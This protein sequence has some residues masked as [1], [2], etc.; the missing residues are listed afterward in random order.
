M[1]FQ[2]IRELL[3]R[4]KNHIYSSAIGRMLNPIG[5]HRD[6]CHKFETS[7]ASFI[8]LAVVPQDPRGGGWNRRILQHET[9]WIERLNTTCWPGINEV[10][11]YVISRTRHS[12]G[13][14]LTSYHTNLLRYVLIGLMLM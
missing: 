7:V 11:T 2:T 10:H 6:L 4:I 13:Y 1:F 9:K 14:S 5:R 12:F 8:V 3:Q